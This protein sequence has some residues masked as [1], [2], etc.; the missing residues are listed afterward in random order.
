MIGSDPKYKAECSKNTTKT[1]NL[2]TITTNLQR[3]KRWRTRER[4]ERSERRSAVVRVFVVV[5]LFP[6]WLYDT[7]TL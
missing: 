6:K 3:R 7:N 1:T 4:N 5:V 2:E